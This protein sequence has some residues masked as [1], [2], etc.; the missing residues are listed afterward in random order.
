MSSKPLEVQVPIT[1]LKI[2]HLWVMSSKPLEVRV[3]ITELPML[4]EE[5]QNRWT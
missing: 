3:S 1:E 2:G 5:N 4:V